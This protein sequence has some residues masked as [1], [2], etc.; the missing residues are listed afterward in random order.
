[1]NSRLAP[2]LIAF[3]VFIIALLVGRYLILPAFHGP[4]MTVQRVGTPAD[5]R[6]ETASQAPDPSA[7]QRQGVDNRSAFDECMDEALARRIDPVEAR[8]TCGVIADNI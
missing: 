5:R 8:H 7:D 3:S 6:L 1:M 2:V 4:D